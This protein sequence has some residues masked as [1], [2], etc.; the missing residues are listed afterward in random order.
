MTINTDIDPTLNSLRSEKDSLAHH[1]KLLKHAIGALESLMSGSRIEQSDTT[2]PPGSAPRD[3]RTT[4]HLAV[5]L[6]ELR[7]DIARAATSKKQIAKAI[8]ALEPLS[9]QPVP[10]PKRAANSTPRGPLPLPAQF[11]GLSAPQRL[12]KVMADQPDKTT[13]TTNELAVATHTGELNTVRTAL[14]RMRAKGEV[15][16]DPNGNW[17]RPSGSTSHPAD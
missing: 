6:D 11:Q 9:A 10:H 1:E 2:N 13:W 4:T 7:G 8:R 17:C 16:Q 12:A 15:D 3:S 14:A 5:T